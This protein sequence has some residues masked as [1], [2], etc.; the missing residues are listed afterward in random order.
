MVL[1]CLPFRS[2]AST[3]CLVML[4]VALRSDV[5]SRSEAIKMDRIHWPK[6]LAAESSGWPVTAVAWK[7]A[8]AAV[9]PT[10]MYS[11]MSADSLWRM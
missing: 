10:V 3:D 1:D 7:M 9:W 6:L 11:Y 4:C 2:K 8:I 5:S